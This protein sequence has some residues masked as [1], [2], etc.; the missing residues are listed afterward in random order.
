MTRL[1]QGIALL[2]YVSSWCAAHDEASTN[3]RKP[4]PYFHCLHLLLIIIIDL[5]VCVAGYEGLQYYQ[6]DI[7]L[8]D[9]QQMTLEAL[10]NPED[11]LSSSP[12]L[13]VVRSSRTLWP[14]GRVP[15]IIDSSLGTYE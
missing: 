3:S 13:A 1:S 12:Q 9:D 10:S 14:E 15:Y 11:V 7:K 4:S 6:G 8:S 5:S 2:L